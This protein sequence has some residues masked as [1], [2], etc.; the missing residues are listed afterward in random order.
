MSSSDT[1]TGLANQQIQKDSIPAKTWQTIL[2]GVSVFYGIFLAFML[3]LAFSAAHDATQLEAYVTSLNLGEDAS[4][5]VT[6]GYQTDQSIATSVVI[7][8]IALLAYSFVMPQLSGP[9]NVATVFAAFLTFMMLFPAVGIMFWV[10]GV[11][12]PIP[13]V[14]L[15]G[16]QLDLRVQVIGLISSINEAWVAG[17]AL[18]PVKI[19]TLGFTFFVYAFVVI[20]PKKAH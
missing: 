17:F 16:V 19:A 14:S 3:Q 11:A 1:A 6:T 13:L 18:L 5:F 12:H 4:K 2:S 9:K 7:G 20:Q 8:M 10:Y 15:S